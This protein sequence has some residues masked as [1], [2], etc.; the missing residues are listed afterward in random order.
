MIERLPAW[1]MGAGAGLWLVSLALP[2]LFA[3]DGSVAWGGA[4]VLLTGL[5]TGW[6][7]WVMPN[8]LGWYANPLMGVALLLVWGGFRRGA[9]VLGGLSFLLAQMAWLAFSQGVMTDE[10]GGDFAY[11]SARSTGFFVWDA[12]LALLAAGLCL[13]VLRPV[14]ARA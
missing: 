6:I 3:P 2:V 7:I 13:R 5:V 9:A 14:P 8:C 12:A 11:L 1:L 4:G 10:S